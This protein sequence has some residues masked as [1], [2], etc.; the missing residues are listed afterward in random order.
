[1]RESGEGKI[2][3]ERERRGWMGEGREG[4]KEGGEGER[5]GREKKGRER[6]GK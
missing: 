6:E 2:E 4:W 3:R 1:M 5:E